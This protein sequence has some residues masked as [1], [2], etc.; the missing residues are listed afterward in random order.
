VVPVIGFVILL[1][2]MINAQVTAQTLGFVWFAIGVVL[3]GVLVAT[4][5]KPE[6]RAEERL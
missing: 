1:Y 6:I 3:M 5:R 2:V 4:G